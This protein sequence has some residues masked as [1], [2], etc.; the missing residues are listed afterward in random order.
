MTLSTA[1]P[2]TQI[3]AAGSVQLSALHSHGPGCLIVNALSAQSG[4]NTNGQGM[5][6]LLTEKD[7]T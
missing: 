2:R 4:L 7:K 1:G 3:V 5:W 6:A